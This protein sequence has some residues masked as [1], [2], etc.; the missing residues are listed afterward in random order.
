MSAKRRR[1]VSGSISD[2]EEIDTKPAHCFLRCVVDDCFR[3][4]RT[5]RAH[6]THLLTIH[7]RGRYDYEK[8]PVGTMG[9]RPLTETRHYIPEQGT[10]VYVS[11]T[12]V[13]YCMD[14][15][16]FYKNRDSFRKH[17][18]RGK[19]TVRPLFNDMANVDYSTKTCNSC[20]PPREFKRVRDLRKHADVNRHKL[21]YGDR[22]DLKDDYY[23]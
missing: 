11:P 18:Q 1:T 8:R 15:K 20:V 9:K 2:L 10:F 12:E 6:L 21:A 16:K 3:L 13:S 7:Y 19:H 4:F 5:R 22:P 17:I 14:C 23:Q